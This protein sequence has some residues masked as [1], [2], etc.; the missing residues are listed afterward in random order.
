MLSKGLLKIKLFRF[1]K[2]KKFFYSL[3]KISI[4]TSQKD[5]IFLF[6]LSKSVRYHLYSIFFDFLTF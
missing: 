2:T 1:L 4:V 6:N 3:I 5:L